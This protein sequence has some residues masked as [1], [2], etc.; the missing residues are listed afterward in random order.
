MIAQPT[1][2]GAPACR[3]RQQPG[4]AR[5]PQASGAAPIVVEPSGQRP[6]F[7]SG[8]LNVD[9]GAQSRG[10]ELRADPGDGLEGTVSGA[11]PP[12]IGLRRM[13]HPGR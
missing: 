2:G 11:R 8:K 7:G 4:S 3:D 1:E 10:A 6:A 9:R 5:R 12:R 13:W